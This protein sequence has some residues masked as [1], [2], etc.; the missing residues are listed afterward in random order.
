M[1]KIPQ[2]NVGE[3]RAYKECSDLLHN[4]YLC[5]FVSRTYDGWL[6]KMR[7]RS[8]G[9]TLIVQASPVGYCIK[10]NKAIIKSDTL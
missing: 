2:R 10:E 9:R 6:A 1:I 3:V 7:H 8:N 4:G 5:L